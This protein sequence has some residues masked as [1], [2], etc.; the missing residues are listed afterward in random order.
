MLW[1]D[2]MILFM[3][4]LSHKSQGPVYDLSHYTLVQCHYENRF[5]MWSDVFLE[6]Y[7]PESLIV[8]QLSWQIP[9]LLVKTHPYVNEFDLF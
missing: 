8:G 4:Y 6:L 7:S 1:L 3:F 9:I 2:S 5:C